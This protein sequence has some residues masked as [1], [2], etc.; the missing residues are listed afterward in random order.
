MAPRPAASC[1][2]DRRVTEAGHPGTAGAEPADFSADDLRDRLSSGELPAPNS[3]GSFVI[4]PV[5]PSASSAR[6]RA[7]SST[8]QT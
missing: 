8:V 5:T 3:R 6:I 7:G 1:E 4:T 2:R